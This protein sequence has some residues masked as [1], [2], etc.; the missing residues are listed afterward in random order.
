MLDSGGKYGLGMRRSLIPAALLIAA[1]LTLAGCAAGSSGGLSEEAAPFSPQQIPA[2]DAGA[3]VESAADGVGRD[4]DTID[5]QVI[6]TG[7]V[8]ITAVDPIGA[9]TEA[10][11]IAE[12]VGGR[13]DGRTERAPVDGDQGSATLTLRLPADSL[14]AT[15]DKLKALGEVEEVALSSNDVTMETQ[16]LDAR[17]KALTASVDRLINLLATATDTE[18]LIQLETAISDRQGELESMQSQRRYLADQVSLSTITLNLISEADAPVDEPD[19]FWSGLLA[20]WD[21][22]VAFFAALLVAFGVSLPWLLLLGAIAFA[23]ILIIRRA[24]RPNAAHASD[25]APPSGAPTA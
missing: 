17:I 8:T 4:A 2:Q 12:S 19:T 24:S 14:T 18:V 7:H 23:V 11:R 1:S 5:R 13:V 10:V 3:E 16:D 22:F 21:G 20:G 15:L 25:T 9:A 6:T